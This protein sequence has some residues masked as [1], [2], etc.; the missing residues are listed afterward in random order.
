MLMTNRERP[1]F[2][3]CVFCGSHQGTKPEYMAAA[4]ELGAAL[5][6]RGIGMVYG[7]SSMGLMGAAA[8]SCL[9]A[10]GYVEGVIPDALFLKE[11]A[12]PRLSKRFV[13]KSM[14][15]RKAM[16]AE[17]ANGF[18]ALP[19]GLGTLE[20]L[21]EIITWAQLGIHAKPIVVWNVAGYYDGLLHFIEQS[22]EQGFVSPL[23]RKV[24]VIRNSLDE[25]LTDLHTFKAP[26][27]IATWLDD[28][29]T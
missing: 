4:Q 2:N 17:R 25:V 23:H 18:V 28:D 29:Q 10:G 6:S 16:M 27:S 22:V 1:A 3:I 26:T 15:A 7:G 14:H 9:A 21:F 20:E 24:V 19:G 11:I 12:H 5:A 8:D 13:V